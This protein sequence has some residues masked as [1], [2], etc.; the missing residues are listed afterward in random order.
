[1]NKYTRSVLIVDDNAVNR[2]L[3]L[4]LLKRRGI[5]AEE[6][7]SGSIAIEK[8]LQGHFN[9]VLLDI[10]MPDMDGKEVCR[11]IRAHPKLNKYWVI[12]YTAHALQSER[13][14]IME[15]GFDELLVKPINS[16]DLERVLPD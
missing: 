13:Q 3:A 11:L 8:L 6:A 16:Q 15:S 14:S 10:C 1:M 12:A 9:S 4:A 5:Y 2:K 7:E